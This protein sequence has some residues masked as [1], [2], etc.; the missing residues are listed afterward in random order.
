[1]KID[2]S[3]ELRGRDGLP[4]LE[5]RPETHEEYLL[6]ELLLQEPLPLSVSRHHDEWTGWQHRRYVIYRIPVE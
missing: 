4:Q 1:M 6:L 5:L 2:F 3:T